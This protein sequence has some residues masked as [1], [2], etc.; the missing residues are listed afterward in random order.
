VN[1]VFTWLSGV[2]A[3]LAV[4]VFLWPTPYRYEDGGLVRVNRFS[5][6]AQKA[7]SEG[8][9]DADSGPPVEADTVTPEVT[10]SFEQVSV[11]AQDFE[12]ITLRNPGPWT[13]TLIEKAQVDFEGCGAGASDY[14]FFLTGDRTLDAGADRVVHLPYPGQLQKVLVQSCGG[15]THKRTITLIINSARNPD[16]R[17]WDAGSKLVTRKFE[18]DVNVPSS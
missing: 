10:K 17:Q 3:V 8:W 1:K 15:K 16:G 6:K 7:G 18:S 14:V 5:G 9:V 4:L 13:L 11:T 2:V 12:S